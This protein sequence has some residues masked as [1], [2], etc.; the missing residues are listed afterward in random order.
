MT[1]SHPGL[2]SMLRCTILST[3]TLAAVGFLLVSPLPAPAQQSGGFC[4]PPDCWA[5]AGSG[6]TRRKPTAARV[7][8]DKMVQR[9]MELSPGWEWVI[10]PIN[11]PKCRRDRWHAPLYH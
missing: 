6:D 1:H 11:H 4:S 7:A 10:L 2:N 5:G 3:A 9:N 8:V